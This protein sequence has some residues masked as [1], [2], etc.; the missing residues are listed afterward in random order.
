MP[1]MHVSPYT[2]WVGGRQF[3]GA[4]WI[5]VTGG[6]PGNT[7]DIERLGNPTVSLRYTT[8]HP[9]RYDQS[10]TFTIVDAESGFGEVRYRLTGDPSVS[11]CTFVAAPLLPAAWR[12]MAG[13]PAG[14]LRQIVHPKDEWVTVVVQDEVNITYPNRSGVFPVVGRPDPVV[15]SDR[16][17]LPQSDITFLVPSIPAADE[18]LAVLDATLPLLLM[19]PC[20]HLVRDR[21]FIP[22][23]VVEQRWGKAG[24]RLIT[25]NTQTVPLPV[26]DLFVP[27]ADA[28]RW[29]YGMLAAN[30]TLPEYG[31]IAPA[32]NDPN[33]YEELR[34]EAIP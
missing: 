7:L 19:T 29:N 21:C 33:D 13:Y 18:L 8:T 4:T 27:D 9:F 25:V 12:E 30:T 17:L 20:D 3:A 10:G 24:W 22:L 26:G 16:R 5:Q 23:D 15:V 1:T 34:I 28:Q 6:T 31:Q 2:G 14:V 32:A 11:D